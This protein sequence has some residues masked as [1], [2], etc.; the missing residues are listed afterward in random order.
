MGYDLTTS[1]FAAL[2]FCQVMARVSPRLTGLTGYCRTIAPALRTALA[3]GQSYS[4]FTD[5][6][7]AATALPE[8][9]EHALIKLGYKEIRF[10]RYY[11]R[12]NDQFRLSFAPTVELCAKIAGAA[13]R[14]VLIFKNSADFDLDYHAIGKA[15][16]PISVF[17][18]LEDNGVLSVN[19]CFEK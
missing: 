9:L 2:R 12:L 4:I 13:L 7:T 6:S 10:Q 14:S 16:I 17:L 19:F 18:R 3:C 15:T 1:A 5:P 8:P 11:N